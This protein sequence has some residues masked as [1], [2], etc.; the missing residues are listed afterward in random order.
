MSVD[1][2]KVLVR[3]HPRGQAS[4]YSPHT[5]DKIWDDKFYAGFEEKYPNEECIESYQTQKNT[6]EISTLPDSVI[7]ALAKRLGTSAVTHTLEHT[8]KS[9]PTYIYECLDCKTVSKLKPTRTCPNCNSKTLCKYSTI[10]QYHT[11]KENETETQKQLKEKLSN[12][13]ISF[14]N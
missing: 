14:I 13:H 7:T 1:Y 9:L 6:P 8:D 5:T 4:G 3:F 10:E 2:L 12:T 11:T